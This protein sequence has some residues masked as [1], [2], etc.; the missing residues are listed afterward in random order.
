MAGFQFRLKPLLQMRERARDQAAQNY[1][2]ATLAVEQL[3]Q[4]IVQL[5]SEYEAQ[6]PLQTAADHQT[7]SPQKVLESQRF[8]L[9]IRQQINAMKQK[10]ILVL[11]ESEKRRLALVEAEKE[12]KS[13]TKLREKQ[14]SEYVASQQA[15]QQNALDQWAG[16]KY[17]KSQQP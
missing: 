13:L 11:Q 12:V 9:Q 8:Q 15:K 5:E 16:I 14:E 2:Q 7:V 6:R 17:W 3:K 4:Q 1:Q 10:L